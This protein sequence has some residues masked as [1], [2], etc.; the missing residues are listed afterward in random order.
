M[1]D[2]TVI[3]DYAGGNMTARISLLSDDTVTLETKENR[4]LWEGGEED[5]NWQRVDRK[6]ATPREAV[7]FVLETECGW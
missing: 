2:S 1:K 6:F 3:L 5:Y 7:L 4:Y